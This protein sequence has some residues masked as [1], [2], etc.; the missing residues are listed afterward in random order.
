LT[1]TKFVNLFAKQGVAPAITYTLAATATVNLKIYKD[2]E[3]V[4]SAI[5][6]NESKAKGTHTSSLDAGLS[7]ADGRYSLE[8]T[9]GNVTNTSKYVQTFTIDRGVVPTVSTTGLSAPEVISALTDVSKIQFTL[10]ERSFVTVKIVQ[11]SLLVNTLVTKADLPAGKHIITWDGRNTKKQAVAT[12]SY[13]AQI[14]LTDTAGNAATSNTNI[15][16]SVSR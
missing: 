1:V 12:G 5:I 3:M 8:L 10:S 13:T 4:G 11:G 16:V 7:L 15:A 6:N 2:N 9:A 14:S